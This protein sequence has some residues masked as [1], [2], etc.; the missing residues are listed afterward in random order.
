MR[1]LWVQV[2]EP[3]VV[4]T[5]R[6]EAIISRPERIRSIV[7]AILL[8]GSTHRVFETISAPVIGYERDRDGDLRALLRR[9]WETSSM[10]DACF[11]T[12]AAMAPEHPRSSR[13][14]ALMSTYD[15]NDVVVDTEVADLGLLLRDVEPVPGSI[16]DGFTRPFPAVRITGPRLQYENRNGVDALISRMPDPA[17]SVAL[18]SDIWLPFVFGSSHPLADH[19]RMFDNRELA[20]RHTPRLN[21]F[22]TDVARAVQAA[23]AEWSVDLELT[24]TNAALWLDAMGI[25]LDAREPDLMP[26]EALDAEWY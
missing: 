16:P 15:R 1:N 13:V 23:G 14:N 21:R 26:P 25:H 6:L 24:G 20:S 7:D 9:R 12:G 2:E 4:W 22:I 11:F 17:I 10:V 8:A 3:F 19:R 5:A 18:H